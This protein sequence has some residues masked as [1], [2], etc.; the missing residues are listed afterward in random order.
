MSSTINP[1]ANARLL[2]LILANTGRKGAPAAAPNKSK[3]T[4]RGWS[5]R[6]KLATARAP[7]GIKTKFAS[8]AK[9]TSLKF[10]SGV[11]ICF[12][13]RPKP[14]ASMLET[15]KTS[16]VIGTALLKSSI[17]NSSLQR[18]YLIG[19][20]LLIGVYGIHSTRGGLRNR[21]LPCER[22][23]CEILPKRL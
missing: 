11:R 14:T 12:K 22:H 1:T 17:N 5:S 4:P 7:N 9:E 10:P 6:S 19:P 18:E 16:T 3:A 20:Q 8:K 21:Y 15:T 13:V 2:L 23:H